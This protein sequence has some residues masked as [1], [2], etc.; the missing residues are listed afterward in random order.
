[1]MT[2]FIPK[3]QI[4]V[5]FSRSLFVT[6]QPNVDLHILEQQSTKIL[7]SHG[8][9]VALLSCKHTERYSI[10]SNYKHVLSC[11]VK[12]FNPSYFHIVLPITVFRNFKIQKNHTLI[13]DDFIKSYDM[14]HTLYPDCGDIVEYDFYVHFQAG[15][16]LLHYNGHYIAFPG[17]LTITDF[18]EIAEENRNEDNI[19]F[20]IV[21][22]YQKHYPDR[23]FLQYEE[24]AVNRS[25]IEHDKKIFMG[26]VKAMSP[27][28]WQ[29]ITLLLK[30]YFDAN[31]VDFVFSKLFATNLDSEFHKNSNLCNYFQATHINDRYLTYG[32]YWSTLWFPKLIT[33]ICK[34]RPHPFFAYKTEQNSIRAKSTS[35]LTYCIRYRFNTGTNFGHRLT[36]TVDFD[37]QQC[38]VKDT[39]KRYFRR[40]PGR[41]KIIYP[42]NADEWQSFADEFYSRLVRHDHGCLVYTI[43]ISPSSPFHLF[44][45]SSV[46]LMPR[47]Y[48]F[49]CR[50]MTGINLIELSAKKS[51]DILDHVNTKLRN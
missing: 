39:T 20:A 11:S 16:R 6:C 45:K 31:I 37:K 5:K 12:L 15:E 3:E 18:Q 2:T 17:T 44:R 48:V 35:A 38:F 42:P 41:E 34:N 29:D 25:A 51:H 8:V 49:G 10:F 23:H 33:F 43:R 22:N 1:M 32:I 30:K 7:F 27:A 9:E 24:D 46:S 26:V 50:H 19:P 4:P 28:G 14:T 36:F 47:S 21:C 40:D 13:I